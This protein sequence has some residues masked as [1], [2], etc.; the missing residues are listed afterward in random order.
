AN[1]ARIPDI[2][3]P[4]F[5]AGSTNAAGT[6]LTITM[7]EPLD[8]SAT[9]G[10]GAFTVTHDGVVQATSTGLSYAGQSLVLNLSS[11]PNNSE[12]VKVRYS[13]PSTAGDR[14]RDTATPTE[15]ESANFGPVAVVNNTTDTVAPSLVSASVN[16]TA[17][18][19]VFSEALA[20]TAPDA[21]AFTVS[22][23]STNRSV[24]GDSMN[25]KTITFT[26]A[27]AVSSRDNVVVS[28][29]VPAMTALHDAAGN[30]TTS[31]VAAVANQTPIVPPADTGVPVTAQATP[32]FVSSSPNDG[33]TVRA[34]STITLTA[35]LS[36]DWTNMNVT[37]PDGSVTALPHA[38]GQ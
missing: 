14:L 29:A 22:T 15:N 16:S 3:A 17:L 10:P 36:A 9:T 38:S 5:L 19:L 18:T 13:Q 32:V 27:P 11:A 33:S 7:S 20:G 4:T 6:Q 21:S 23:G 1:V 28:Y 24:T 34:V 35:S 31:F 2:T 30:A 37:R 25:G 12:S 8:A 26:I